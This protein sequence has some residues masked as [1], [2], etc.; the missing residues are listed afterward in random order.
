MNIKID[1]INSKKKKKKNR[2]LAY[3]RYTFLKFTFIFY[4]DY[5]RD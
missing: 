4:L 1:I 3:S 2:I 5:L